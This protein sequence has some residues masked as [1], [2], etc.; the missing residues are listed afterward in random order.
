[1]EPIIAQV[2]G[3]IPK[4]AEQFN[5]IHSQ[6]GGNVEIEEK[7]IDTEFESVEVWDGNGNFFNLDCYPGC[8]GKAI[9]NGIDSSSLP[10]VKKLLK[11]GVKIAQELGY[12]SVEYTCIKSQKALYTHLNKSS[13]FKRTGIAKGRTGNSMYTYVHT[14]KK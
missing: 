13:K 8:C 4:F 11:L 5:T 3:D 12:G 6:F 2:H 9:M 10:R 14:I 1:M 7:D